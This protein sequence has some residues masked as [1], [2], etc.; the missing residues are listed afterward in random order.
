MPDP[1]L[2]DGGVLTGR[3]PLYSDLERHQIRLFSMPEVDG[4]ERNI[5]YRIDTF[6]IDQAPPYKALSYAWGDTKSDETVMIDGHPVEVTENLQAALQ[7]LVKM[8]DTR[9]LW[10]DAICINQTNIAEKN[11]QVSLMGEIYS[12]ALKVVA[13]LGESSPSS[14]LALTKLAEWGRAGSSFHFSNKMFSGILQTNQPE[15]VWQAV[16]EAAQRARPSTMLSF[17][18]WS[19]QSLSEGVGGRHLRNVRTLLARGSFWRSLAFVQDPFDERPW[20]ALKEL[21]RRPYWSRVWTIQEYSLAKEVSM[22]CG[23]MECDIFDIAYAGALWYQ[24][25]NTQPTDPDLQ[26]V[27][28]IRTVIFSC[29]QCFKVIQPLLL[30]R[31]DHIREDIDLLVAA[32]A[33]Q[34]TTDPRDK[35]YGVMSLGDPRRWRFSIDY[36]KSMAE[37]YTDF[38]LSEIEHSG[39][40]RTICLLQHTFHADRD[41]DLPSWVPDLSTSGEPSFCVDIGKFSADHGEDAI[42]HVSDDRRELTV[43]G[44]FFDTVQDT[45]E[46]PSTILEGDG[47]QRNINLWISERYNLAL[48]AC[49]PELPSGVPFLQVLLRTLIRDYSGLQRSSSNCPIR[50]EEGFRHLVTC[51][52]GWFANSTALGLVGE[53]GTSARCT[54]E[55]FFSHFQDVVNR[56]SL[57]LLGKAPTATDEDGQKEDTAGFELDEEVLDGANWSF[58]V[59]LG[60][61]SFGYTFFVTRNRYM[62]L[63][64][65]DLRPTDEIFVLLGLDTPVA[66][67]RVKGAG[68]GVEDHYVLVGDCY[69]CDIMYGSLVVEAREGKREWVDVVLR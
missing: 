32:T 45:I 4:V 31:S 7:R 69:V 62:G 56:D 6:D 14:D 20:E 50:D 2:N 12:K 66:L 61:F 40:L 25:R 58:F 22:V 19:A 23:G 54:P 48:S 17:D 41:A 63:G 15:S 59:A 1:E 3:R 47:Y 9:R 34:K 16:Q 46:K 26:G 44:L 29:E 37:V 27:S 43:G 49:G 53:E 28:S 42:W 8:P 36:G 13:W 10:I 57:A 18:L 24:L 64:P 35:I 38:V 51:A 68:E 30:A 60:L 11:T 55:G 5:Q 21:F 39:R 67:R 65:V 33:G 52:V